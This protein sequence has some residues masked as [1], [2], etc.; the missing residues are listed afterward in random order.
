MQV[1]TND[2]DWQTVIDHTKVLCRSWQD[3]R[4]ERR[5]VRYIRVVGTRNTASRVF[6]LVSLEAYFCTEEVKLVE[7]IIQPRCN[8]ATLEKS[9]FIIE[10]VSRDRNALINGDTHNF[11]WDSG[12]TCHQLKNGGITVHLAQPYLITSMKLLLW[13]MDDRAYS[14]Y[15]QFSLNNV[16]WQEVVDKRHE[17]CKSWQSLEIQPTPTCFIRIVGTNN[18]ANE[19]FHCV[20]FE[21]SGSVLKDQPPPRRGASLPQQQ[22]QLQHPVD[23]I[24]EM[25]NGSSDQILLP[26]LQDDED[27]GVEAA[28]ADDRS[29][30]DLPQQAE[31]IN[32]QFIDLEL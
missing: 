11:D 1:S 4:F 30:D 27:E 17:G 18:T 6:Q 25:S 9:A 28:A 7:G 23:L 31:A 2:K 13:D 3:L 22:Q 24:E 5:V 19:V 21:C 20:H 15:I 29:G 14:Y 32:A 12:Y 10:G 8:V 16:T 26:A